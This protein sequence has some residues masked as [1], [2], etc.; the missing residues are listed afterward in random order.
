[1]KKIFILLLTCFI[2]ISSC[3]NPEKDF[4]KAKEENTIT[5]YQEFIDKHPKSEFTETAKD[6]LY[7]LAYSEVKE[8][9]DI[10]KCDEY[11]ESYPRSEYCDSVKAI[12]DSLEKSK[13]QIIYLFP[14]ILSYTQRLELL[15]FFKRAIEESGLIVVDSQE[16]PTLK[17][18]LDLTTGCRFVGG[19]KAVSIM[20]YDVTFICTWINDKQ[21]FRKTYKGEVSGGDAHR[22]IGNVT[23]MG[24]YDIM[25]DDLKQSIAKKLEDEQFTN[26]IQKLWQQMISTYH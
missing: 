2:F 5:A 13:V 19:G 22:Q 4:Q 10:A 6:I 24:C 25:F 15:D 18:S 21:M 20:S 14:E 23:Y 1:M 17:I 9:N 3:T 12:I 26:S 11:L 8:T 7:R 16:A